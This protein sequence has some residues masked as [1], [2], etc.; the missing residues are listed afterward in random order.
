MEGVEGSIMKERRKTEIRKY[1]DGYLTV[2]LALSVTILLSLILMLVEGARINAARAR[3]EIAGNI[4]V[5]SALGEFHKELLKQYDLYFIDTSYCS[6]S[7]S[8]E[9]LQ[10][11]VKS[12]MSR[13]LESGKGPYVDLIRLSLQELTIDGTR[14]AA[15]GRGTAIREQV[16]AYMSADPAGRV[17]ADILTQAD[18]WQGLRDDGSAWEEQR[19]EARENLREELRHAREDLN[20][21][22]TAEERKEAQQEGDNT[23][24]KALEAVDR[25]RLLPI[26]R[27]VFGDVSVISDI[28]AGQNVLSKR[29]IHYGSL[30]KPDNSHGYPGADEALFDL[31]I[32]EKCGCYTKPL[33]KGFMK[34]QMEYILTGKESDRAALERVAEE[35]LLIREASNCACLFTDSARIGQAET[36]AAIVS[37]VLLNPELKEAFKTVLLFA[38]AYMESI[39][40]LRVLFKGGRIPL[41]KTP[42]TWRTSLLSILTPE[43]PGDNGGTE[44]GLLYTDY[45][46]ALLYLEGRSKKTMRTMDVMEMDIRKTQGNAGF[47][48]DWCLDAFSMTAAVR[49]RSGYEFIL[50]KSEGYN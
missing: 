35:L 39:R 44:T 46:Q 21:N 32:G 29:T 18:V 9:N 38:W 30:L 26:L 13:N 15:D 8:V 47:R 41:R 1:E 3:A 25:F 6:G 7:A 40:D 2:F 31:Y 27:Q 17:L 45:L 5:R 23:A 11:H 16:Y 20:E 43:A 22:T 19:R 28:S 12:Y 48:M 33:E 36:L 10:E 42:D 4:A 34:Y 49:S 37:I 24:E 14:F 50:K